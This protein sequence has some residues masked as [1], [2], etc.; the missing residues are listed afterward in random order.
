MPYGVESF[1]S[2]FEPLWKG[3]RMHHGKGLAAFLKATGYIIPLMDVEY[4]S[5][6]T[7]EVI[8]ECLKSSKTKNITLHPGNDCFD[9]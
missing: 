5:Y 8:L 6:Y 9:S 4:A 1:D 3:I 7:K 2:V